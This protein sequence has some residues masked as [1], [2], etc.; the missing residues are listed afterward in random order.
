MEANYEYGCAGNRS[1]F[2][3]SSTTK[4][5][6]QTKAEP[7]ACNQTLRFCWYEDEVFAYGNR[8]V[9]QDSSEKRILYNVALRC[10]KKLGIC[11]VAVNQ[12]RLLFRFGTAFVYFAV[13]CGEANSQTLSSLFPLQVVGD[14][15]KL[16]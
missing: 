7:E 3:F 1:S 2:S 8:W 14:R 6:P 11:A 15:F 9:P 16:G 10:I 12:L 5:K 13:Q 4:T